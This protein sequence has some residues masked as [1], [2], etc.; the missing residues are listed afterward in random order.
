[1]GKTK[2]GM[3]KNEKFRQRGRNMMSRKYTCLILLAGV[4][5]VVV[6]IMT[7]EM[8]TVFEKAIRICMECIG[9]G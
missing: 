9:I 6:G 7:E 4:V 8:N 3:I 2:K 1:M 5:M